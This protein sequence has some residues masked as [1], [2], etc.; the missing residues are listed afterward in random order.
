[1]LA[2]KLFDLSKVK[3][4]N[5]LLPKPMLI[6][7]LAFTLF[8]WLSQDKNENTVWTANSVSKDCAFMDLPLNCDNQRIET[9][10]MGVISPH[11]WTPFH[12]YVKRVQVREGGSCLRG[13]V[14]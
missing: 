13:S 11:F 3:L 8:V 10:R 9:E 12:D 7:G 2:M 5:F 4:R 14:V 6:F 1:M